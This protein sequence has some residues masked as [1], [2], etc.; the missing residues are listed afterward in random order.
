MSSES[1]SF[2][3][4]FRAQTLRNGTWP[5][6][7]VCLAMAVYVAMT[8][9]QPNRPLIGG[10]GVAALLA[11]IVVLRLPLESI[12][13]GRWREPFCVSWSAILIGFI[14]VACWADGGVGAPLESLFFLPMIFAALSYP[15]LSTLL[16]GAGD[17]GA[18]LLVAGLS[19][20]ESGPHVFSFSTT[21]AG[22]AWICAWQSRNHDR[23]RRRLDLASRTDPLTGCL[24]RR[25]FGESFERLMAR[26]RRTGSTVTLV[27]VDLDDFKAVNDRDG[28][29]AGDELLCWVGARLRSELRAGD[30]VARLGGDEF[31]L[32]MPDAD[33]EEA[34]GRVAAALAERAPASVGA[35][36]F[37]DDGA[38]LD[39][40]ARTADGAL[41]ECK[42][43]RRADGRPAATPV[44][45]A[46]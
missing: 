41:Y 15:L 32:L 36:V 39:A 44:R 45:A 27:L 37:P 23:H 34:V 33:S 4:G 29:A 30:V 38:D 16:V 18:Y 21:L 35:A 13:R 3:I 10:L 24:N 2:A 1:D 26:C 40:L 31:A 28:H 6:M 7:F 43:E 19:P 11:S 22:A 12:I 25:G 46:A 42:R 14:A 5:T 17:V 9:E 8:P 20:A